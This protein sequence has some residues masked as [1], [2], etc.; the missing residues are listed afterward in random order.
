MMLNLLLILGSHVECDKNKLAIL[1]SVQIRQAADHPVGDRVSFNTVVGQHQVPVVLD[2]DSTGYHPDIS[3]PL[4]NH[5]IPSSNDAGQCFTA[6][7][8]PLQQ[9]VTLLK[10]KVQIVLLC[11]VRTNCLL[12]LS[13]IDGESLQVAGNIIP[14]RHLRERHRLPLIVTLLTTKHLC[15][16]AVLLWRISTFCHADNNITDRNWLLH[17]IRHRVTDF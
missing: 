11:I 7:L 10:N 4:V 16:L 12:V 13:I 15:V 1:H 17:R 5:S 8:F 6:A 3:C 9:M 2:G 14:F